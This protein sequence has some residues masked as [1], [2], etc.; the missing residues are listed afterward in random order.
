MQILVDAMGGDNAP[1]EIVNGCI[2][3]VN[4]SSG[5]KLVLL[6]NKEQI[7]NIAGERKFDS[8]RIEIIPTRN[9]ITN[10]DSPATAIRQKKDSSIVKGFN[11]LKEKVGDAFISAG[12][13]GALM[14]GA[15]LILGRIKGVDRPALAPIIPTRSGGTMLIDAGLN[16]SCKPINYL[17]F[18]MIGSIYMKEMFNLEKPKV[19]LINVGSEQKKGNEIIRQAYAELMNSNINFI[20]NIEGKDIPSGKVNVAVCDGFVGN[21]LLK[22]LEGYASFIFD[23]LKEVYSKN[24]FSKLSALVAKDE[25][26]S[27]RK[28]LDS[29]E[30][31]GTPILGVNGIVFKSH[32]SSKAKAIKNAV[33]RAYDFTKTS[34]LKQIEENFANME[35]G[36]LGD[37]G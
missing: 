37:S 16:T 28:R 30:Y 33:I 24:L 15:L 7:E 32:G 29:D 2:D 11:L 23:T 20:G 19:G 1:D 36:E 10:D 26:K 25:L 31:G 8:S 3:A 34:V 27:F 17:Q 12:N 21:I 22:F 5:F 13:T 35:V 18:G 6:G 14:A 9:E 4:E